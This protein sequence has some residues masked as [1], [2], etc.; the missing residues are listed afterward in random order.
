MKKRTAN[1]TS[2]IVPQA[3]PK[4]KDRNN[5]LVIKALK[6]LFNK[7]LSEIDQRNR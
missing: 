2:Q 3:Y 6:Q 5:P 4:G 7:S 1:V